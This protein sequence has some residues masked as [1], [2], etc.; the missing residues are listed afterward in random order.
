MT[1][2]SA[3]GLGYRPPGTEHAA[4]QGIDLNVAPG[5]V[6][7]LEGPSG[8]GKST[9]LR[10]L[11]GLAPAFHGGEAWGAATVAGCDLRRDPPARIAQHVALL[12]QDPELQAV[13]GEPLRDAAFGLQCRGWVPE[14]ILPAARTALARVRAEHLIGRRIDELSSGERQRV[15]LA[16]VLAP[17]PSVLLLDEPTAQLD[18]DAACDLAGVLRSL[19]DRGLAIVIA[20]HRRDRVGHLA[21][22]VIG[23]AA[24]RLA[25]PPAPAAYPL[26]TIHAP[27]VSA[28]AGSGLQ[29]ARAGRPVIEEASFD[30]AAGTTV[31]LI[32]PNGSGKSTLLRAIAGLEP[33]TAGS[34]IAGRSL[35]GEAPGARVD[36]IRMLPQDPGRFLL[37]DTVGDEIRRSGGDPHAFARL[38]EALELEPLLQRHPRSLSVG[39]RERVAL[40]AA[41]AP[42]SPVLLLDEPTRGMDAR[43]REGLAVLL[44]ERAS[45]GGATVLATHD[46]DL[47][48]AVA[49]AHWTLCE[50]RLIQGDSPVPRAVEART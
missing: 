46:L 23:L 38:V 15:A 24:G 22:R 36:R 39:E 7:L 49:D 44:A 43:R 19:A 34:L 37:M 4:L 16:G 6:V 10:L 50:Q 33:V 48:R 1:A 5:E 2:I 3:R 18:D 45:A 35:D 17:E 32:G 41:M 40:A 29:V 11:A 47:A 30:V 21:D 42:A 26:R 27:G 9:L 8:S 13:M 28:L 12:F 20:E 25:E 14:R 31:A